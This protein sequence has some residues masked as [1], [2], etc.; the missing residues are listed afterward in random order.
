MFGVLFFI[1]SG[2]M[3]VAASSVRI[4]EEPNFPSA[5]TAPSS[6]AGLYKLVPNASFVRVQ[7]LATAL[8]GND[9]SLLILPYGSAFPECAWSGIKSYLDR[10]GN[11]LVLGGRP[12]T[13]AAYLSNGAWKLRDYS[14][15]FA[16]ELR[17]DQYESTAGSA[18]LRFEDNPDVVTKL[19]AF[20]WQVSYS[21]ILHLSDSRISERGGSAGRID[22][23]LSALSWGVRDGQRISAPAVQ[24]DHLR[25]DFRGGR[26]VFMNAELPQGFA[27]SPDAR[28]IVTK[29]AGTAMQGAQW[30][31]VDPTLPLYVT[32]EPIELQVSW[33]RGST[34][35]TSPMVRVTVFPETDPSQRTV[36]TANFTDGMMITLPSSKEK[37]FHE[38]DADL[39]DG[40]QVIAIYHSGFWMR[41]G[42]YLRSGPRLTVDPNY[43]ELNG[44]PLAVVGSTY[45][46]SDV[47]R[48][49][50]EHPNAYVWNRDLKQIADA[51]VNMI[52]TGWWSGWDK[53]CDENGIPYERTSR[54]LE[55]YLMTARKYGLPVQF[56]VFAF[57]PDVLGGE[58]GYLDP[59]AVAREKTLYSSLARSFQDVPFLAW[60]L[61]N[62]P[63]F[64]QHVWTALP[65][66]DPL[67]LAEWNT[68]LR[69]RYPTREALAATWNVAYIPEDAVIPV[70]K[71]AEYASF[72]GSNAGKVHDFYL[73]SQ[74]KFAGWVAQMRTTIHETGSQQLITVG[75]D[76]GGNSSRLLASYFVGSVD[77]TANH[78]WFQDDHLLWNSLVA[79][80]IGKPMLIQEMGVGA[81]T[82]P[83]GI[84]RRSLENQSALFERKMALSFAQG[85]GAI[86]WLWNTN[87][88]MIE[89]GEVALGGVRADG[90]EKP[91]IRVLREFGD[92][93][94][95]ASDYLRN[96][97]RPDVVI[98]TSQAAQF[99]PMQ[100]EQIQAQQRSVQAL[101]YYAR[102]PGYM[103]AENAIAKLGNPKLVILPSPQ[104]LG[105]DT[106][107]ALL[108][109]V[110]AGGSLLVT[111]PVN[112]DAYW[113]IVDRLRN[114]GISGNVEP[115]TYRTAT[116][117]ETG[118][119]ITISFDQA[120]QKTLDAI[121]FNDSSSLEL[122][123][124]GQGH[125][126]WSS[127]PLELG[128]QPEAVG[129]LYSYVINKVGITPMFDLD[130]H[131][132]PGVL[133]YPTVLQNAVMYIFASTAAADTAIDIKDR[134][135]A[136]RITFTL[137]SQHA[138][139]VLLRKSDGKVVARFQDQGF[140]AK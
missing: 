86:E 102:T 37:G 91:E 3:A 52:R 97:E 4:L 118:E 2:R 61:I 124:Y 74:E 109:Y 20:P 93:S 18:G 72:G 125:I 112:R 35:P 46:A 135:T 90:T 49:Y 45:M 42:D 63:S 1:A 104:A 128:D 17:I 84:E 55:A 82:G 120:R 126:F 30:F 64:G 13:R 38:V 26:W 115:L 95:A 53:L 10:G 136:T 62:E 22:S 131:L 83:D 11:L 80:Q 54:T 48:L 99:S 103:I 8:A 28:S 117:N 96:P 113:H 101:C 25:G 14:V 106:W 129:R 138:A 134:M 50:F 34:I 65:N 29:L 56:N 16:S 31:R 5:D 12:F 19:P 132:S 24:I 107:L 36:R 23:I 47:Q 88:D 71:A 6:D 32:G 89:N 87:A 121:H 108:A 40:T 68:W 67:E 66:G 78:A 127:D 15:R 77:F 123:S 92:F 27:D 7:E 81:G 58:N 139:I 73:F 44:K 59:S 33:L 100:S 85:S 60:D 51:G 57:L 75:Q 119:P 122:Q 79:K 137:S 70:P 105:G 94:K 21:P 110:K 130:T 39:L 9:T 116:S 41:D 43:L 114:V 76:E 140:V 98:V 133:V 111:G 69:Q